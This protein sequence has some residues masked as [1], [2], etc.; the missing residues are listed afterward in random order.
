LQQ[1]FL[2]LFDKGDS[3]GPFGPRYSVVDGWRLRGQVDPAALQGALDDIVLRHEA[4]RTVVVRD[5]EPRYQ[6]VHPAASPRL[7]IRD[8]GPADPADPPHPE[9]RDIRAE[10]FLNEIECAPVSPRA[11]PLISAVLGR[12]DERDAVL[13][14]AAHHTAVDGW[15]MQVLMRDLAACYAARC[16]LGGPDLPEVEQYRGFAVRQRAA[17]AAGGDAPHL[18]FWREKLAGARITPIRTDRD[19]S[20]HPDFATGWHRFAYGPDARRET[21]RGAA[22]LRGSLFMTLLGA[23]EVLLHQQTGAT[24]I[25]V[26]TFTP[27]RAESRLQGSVGSFFNFLPLRVDLAGARTFRDVVDRT[28]AGCLEAYS[29]ELPLPQILSAAPEL[30]A[31]A[32]TDGLAACVFQ[33]IQYPFLLHRRTVGDLEYTALRNRRISQPVGS[34]IPD[35]ALWCLELEPDGDLIGTVGYS[36]NL[37]EQG[38][39][40]GMVVRYG[41]LLRRLVADPDAPLPRA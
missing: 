8:L 39:V 40:A 6:Q 1:E 5:A 27:G 41:A 9:H 22:T 19:R 26:P 21:T 32:A 38:T 28:K 15:S 4:L 3:A 36:S 35:G 23:F 12:F 31:P 17:E 18:A 29:H 2:C 33:V 20:A 11:V 14:L 10:E 7:E 13:V 37:L 24:D 30:M 34:D 25:V 16:G